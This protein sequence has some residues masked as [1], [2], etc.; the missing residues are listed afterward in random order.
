MTDLI[1]P[2]ATDSL[3]T[4]LSYLEKSH[5]KPI[6]MGLDRIRAVAGTLNLLNP[7]PY[8]ITVAGTNGQPQ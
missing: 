7:A 8:V 1:I 5:F 2:K 6:D 4:W 3:E